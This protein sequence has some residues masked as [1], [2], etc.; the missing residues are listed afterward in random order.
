[1]KIERL[2]IKSGDVG[3]QLK[4]YRDLLGQEIK[5]YKEESF[6]VEVGYSILKLV[7][8]AN[9][10]P[11]HIAIHIP[12]RQEEIALD[13]IKDRVPVLKHNND[14]II[15]FSNWNA[16]SLYFY[17]AD[18]NIMEFISRK[19]FNKPESAIFSEESLLGIAEVGLATD[20]IKE[21]FEFLH[22]NCHLG[23]FDGSFEKFCAIGDDKGLLITIDK[24]DKDW[25]PTKDRAFPSDFKI[26][27][28]HKDQKQ[29]LKFENNRLDL[30][31]N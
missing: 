13:W 3:E 10:T 22:R 6:E 24:N 9:A 2:E 8:D 29:E 16:K 26:K 12:D 1:M 4:F 14:E 21:K 23:I 18:K 28:R 11:Y 5:N 7:Q 15:D 31:N 30:I 27:F 20:D 25:F 19:S 17:D